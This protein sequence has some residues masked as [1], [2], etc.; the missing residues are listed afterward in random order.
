MKKNESNDEFLQDTLPEIEIIDLDESEASV[1][2][3]EAEDFME[4]DEDDSEED[5]D[6]APRG[7]RRFFNVHLFFGLFC[8]IV[9][10]VVLFRVFHW[11]SFVDLKE[12]FKDGEGTYD[13]TYDMILP[14]TDSEGNII[15]EEAKNIVL[16]GNS[17]FSDDRNSSNGLVALMQEQTSATIYNCS[18]SGS[19]LASYTTDITSS[20]HPMDAYTLYWL[21]AL[22]TERTPKYYIENAAARL[23]EEIPADAAEVLTTLDELDFSTVDTVVIMYDATD[24]LEGHI[25]TNDDNEE[26]VTTFTGNL[27]ASINQLRAFNP[28][29]RIIV[30]S[31]TYAYAIDENGDYISSDKYTYNNQDVLSGYVIKECFSCTQLGSVTFLDHIYGTITEDNADDY[32]ADN[33]HL[34]Q[35]GRALVAERFGYAL[36]YYVE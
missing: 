7:I 16:F 3:E 25:M 2:T 4:M 22:A 35:A 27:V 19:Y 15:R 13:N 23:G 5:E 9:I 31:P 29:V 12:V 17:P 11:G 24:Y 26:D 14:A 36:N 30:M 8:L 32:L 34:N 18:I 28:D 20:E 1:G 33:L 6:D 10:V 21:T